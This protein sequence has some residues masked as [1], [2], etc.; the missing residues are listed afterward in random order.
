MG[1]DSKTSRPSFWQS[2][3]FIPPLQPLLIWQSISLFWLCGI[4]AAV[5]PIAASI[6]AA[7]IFFVD[8]RLRQKARF[9]TAIAIFILGFLCLHLTNPER[10]PHP[11]W[12]IKDQRPLLSRIEGTV[13]KV[14]GLANKR[15]RITLKN[16]RSLEHK[17]APPLDGLLIWTWQAAKN[18]QSFANIKH[19]QI[20]LPGQKI[21]ISARIRTTESFKN[22]GLSSFGFYWQTQGIFWRIWSRGDYGKPQ[23]LGEPSF[24]ANLRQK[25]ISRLEQALF[26]QQS[27]QNDIKHQAYA[28]L[29]SLLFGN[30]YHLSQASLENMQG[31]SLIHSLAL[32]GQ[33]LALVGLIAFMF[34]SLVY[35]IFPNILLI[36]P[37]RKWLGLLSLPLAIV[38]L[39]LGNAPP[40]LIRAALMLTLALIFFWKMKASTLGDILLT[41][42]LLITCY[43]PSAIFNLGLQLS[44]LC[45]A[46]IA[47]VLPILRRLPQINMQ[48]Q[49]PLII[50][51]IKLLRAITQIFIISLTI[52]VALL[53][54]FL[55]YFAPSGPWF[56]SN[57]FWLP[58]LGFWVLPLS[59]LGLGLACIWPEAIFT[60]QILHFAAWPCELLLEVLQFM[61]VENLFNFPP[62]LRPHWSAFLAWICL[63]LALAHAVGRHKFTSYKQSTTSTKT[64]L[65]IALCLLFTGPTIRYLGYLSHD[66]QI[67]TLD[68]GQGQA[69]CI[70]LSGG[71]RILIDGG[72]SFSKT[73]DTGKALVIPS[74]LYNAPPRLYAVINS[75]PDMDHLRG[76]MAVLE[77]MQ[78][79]TFYHNGKKFGKSYALKLQEL[80]QKNILPPTKILSAGMTLNLPSIGQNLKLEVL[81]PPKVNNF[82]SNNASI[83]LRLIHE[84]NNTKQGIALI[85]GDAEKEALT[86]ILNSK[87]ILEASMII[88]PHHGSKDA[89]LP[90]FYNKTKAKV[91][92][93]SAAKHN[94]AGF[95]NKEVCEALTTE[96]IKLYST[97]KLGAINI[98]WSNNS[99]IYKLRGQSPPPTLNI[100]TQNHITKLALKQIFR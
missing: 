33:H 3:E 55:Y 47:L 69:V 7:M 22:E 87:Q 59:A 66:V 70:T 97:S 21:Q 15:L 49:S 46:S 4:L 78:V 100:K 64:L 88:L 90:S 63:C 35:F 85:C 65:F 50:F 11:D 81:N 94:N 26:T 58:I 45:V 99:N 17:Y 24:A 36:L 44:V 52:Q 1:V 92:I 19:E 25:A 8:S 18:K 12:A 39:W 57:I 67:N 34:M 29:P 20:P 40:S 68:V 13:S 53:P 73:F 5:F 86:G 74:L 31:S 75:H 38:Y 72:G 42:L 54:I 76:L 71:E 10:P 93:A 6:A 95:P 51:I 16:V 28:F 23:I 41:T 96:N 62:I 56:I 30:K 37:H 89:L 9:F 77:Q 79:G 27:T 43:N 82:S 83:V 91:A 48:N 14:E 80:K 61:R 60:T 32:S 84:N 2:Q 98:I